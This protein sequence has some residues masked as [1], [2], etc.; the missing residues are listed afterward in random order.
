MLNHLRNLSDEEKFA[1]SLTIQKFLNTELK[2]ESGVWAG[3]KA[4]G[5]E[6]SIEW[7][8]AAPH[9]TWVFPV[10]SGE[11]LKFKTSTEGFS[12]ASLG[13]EEPVG[14]E[15]SLDEISGFVVPGV[16][17]D[18]TGNRLGRGGGFYDRTLK[19]IN[20]NK[21]GVCYEVSFLKVIPSEDHD[22]R[23]NKIITEKQ[24]YTVKSEGVQKWN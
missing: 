2:S 9:L 4:M 1:A 19:N 15:V 12:R 8:Q 7:N 18:K 23:C 21:I 16:G 5:N 6:P 22:V 14:A 11:A 13:F 20:K 3:F 24:V 17:F 10:A